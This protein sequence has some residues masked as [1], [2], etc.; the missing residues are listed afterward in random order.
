MSSGQHPSQPWLTPTV[1]VCRSLLFIS[2]LFDMVSTSHAHHFQRVHLLSNDAAVD[3]VSSVERMEGAFATALLRD[4]FRLHRYRFDGKGRCGA[5]NFVR[6]CGLNCSKYMYTINKRQNPY[7][8]DEL[9]RLLGSLVGCEYLWSR[10]RLQATECHTL[11]APPRPRKFFWPGH[12]QPLR[13][14]PIE[15]MSQ[16]YVA[17][18]TSCQC[19]L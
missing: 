15:L 4:F 17:T 13:Q 8:L 12:R 2:W 16:L 18:M 1:Y 19:M 3:A 6:P 10:R 14:F 5:V 11:Y 9:T 7:L